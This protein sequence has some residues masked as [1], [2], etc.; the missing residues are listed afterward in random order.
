MLMRLIFL[1]RVKMKKIIAV[2][3]V[4]LLVIIA[5]CSSSDSKSSTTT[6]YAANGTIVDPYIVGAVM[7]ED[8]DTS[9]TCDSGEQESTASNTSGIFKFTE[10]LTAGSHVI[11]K[12]HGKH[13]G[14]TY[15][16]DIS[17]V[18]ATDGSIDVVSPI[19]T[20][21]TKG[22]SAGEIGT[23]LTNAGLTNFTESDLFGDPMVGGL[24][25]KKLSELSDSDLAHLQA[26]LAVYG[27]L[28]VMDGSTT[29]KNKSKTE[30]IAGGATGMPINQILTAMVTNIKNAL[31]LT[32]L[33]TIN[34]TVT[35]AKAG[36]GAYAGY[37]PDVT[38]ETVIK[39]AVAVM[40]RLTTIG[41][42]T[43]NVTSGTDTEKVT[44]ALTQVSNNASAVTANIASLGQKYYGKI[45]KSA[46]SS[47]SAYLPTDVAAGVTSTGDAF[48]INSGNGVEEHSE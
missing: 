21:E 13:E 37:I 17:G 31:N 1:R 32:N 34:N 45:N 28:R 27:L 5:G 29:L 9:G 2:G 12:T 26:S 30:I 48:I 24:K 11:V 41:Y 3:L 22:L 10:S 25:D 18:V 47:Y 7:C 35:A 33:T 20:L 40:N 44:A 19:T 43:C 23:M 42:T 6:T 36:A 15:N 4:S 39:T 8:K 38:L 46:L 16:L 14:V